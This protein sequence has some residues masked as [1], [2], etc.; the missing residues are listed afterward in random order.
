VSSKPFSRVGVFPVVAIYVWP[1]FFGSSFLAIGSLGVG[2][3]PLT[4]QA[5][6]W[7]II[8]YLQSDQLGQ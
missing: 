5:F 1:G 6:D 4:A 3:F 8:D 2:W 7:A